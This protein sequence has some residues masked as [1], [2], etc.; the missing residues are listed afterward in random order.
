MALSRLRKWSLFAL[1]SLLTFSLPSAAQDAT[2]QNYT[3]GLGFASNATLSS[4]ADGV[5]PYG[6][7]FD[8]DV[9]EIDA[10]WQDEYPDYEGDTAPILDDSDG[11][12]QHD[13]R[14]NCGQ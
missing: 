13:C 7:G 12:Q 5:Q 10:N 2:T 14:P 1:V 4:N 9:V 6:T 8:P 11:G 3:T